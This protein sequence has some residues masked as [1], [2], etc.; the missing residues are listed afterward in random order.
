MQSLNRPQDLYA[1]GASFREIITAIVKR[2]ARLAGMPMALRVARKVPRLTLDDDGNV[3]DYDTQDPLGTITLLI[4]QYEVLYGEIARTLIRQAAQPLAAVTDNKLLREVGLSDDAT[5]PMRVLLVDD[6]V[7]FREAL[8]SLLEAQPD[9]KVV[10]QADSMRD[11]IALTRNVLPDLVLMNITL[12]D[13]TGAEAI[14]AILAE[15]PE[16]KIVVLTLSEEDDQLFE[17]I[18]AGAIGYLSKHVGVAVLFKTLQGVMRGEAGIS[19]TTA[20][21]ILDEFA[22]LSPTR[23]DEGATLT[24]REVEVLRELA[25]G[26]SNHVI[27]E[28]LVISEN[29]VKNHVRNILVKLHFH[30]RREAANYARRHGLSSIPPSICLFLLMTYPLLDGYILGV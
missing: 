29:T 22:R 14:R 20:R 8:V 11:A 13:G 15:R 2:F 25:N 7:L 19:G 27:A 21:R 4:D 10:G 1:E 26:A 9:L 12:P 23:S 17:A 3:L 30:S 28:R 24:S 18:R 16:T 6:H 5:I